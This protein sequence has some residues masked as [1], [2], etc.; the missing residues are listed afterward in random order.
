VDSTLRERARTGRYAYVH[1]R[2]PDFAAGIWVI[3]PAF[4]LDALHHAVTDTDDTQPATDPAYFAGAHLDAPDLRDAL[5][6][7]KARRHD[8]RQRHADAVRTNLGLG[9]D[10]RAGLID[11]TP[12]Q[13]D[14]LRVIVCRLL[15]RE[16]RDVLAYGAGWT[17]PDRQRPIGESGRH[18]PMPVD[19]II[20]AELQRALGETDPLR[21]IAA[22]V[23]RLA[24]AFVLDPDGITRTKTLGHERMSRKLDEALPGGED[25]LREALWSFLRP[26]LSPRLADLHRDTFITD[27][28]DRSTVDL[29]AQ[30]ADT[31]LDDLEL[32]EPSAP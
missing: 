1:D 2:G 27:P 21:G 24:A 3:D 8:Q 20:D 26:M 16:Y 4:M 18:E 11:P 7:E 22:L 30:R 5:A 19:A 32:D 29:A 17:D 9:H 10:L 6:D 13:L 23:A 15:A 14:A 12:S 28:T 31:N 25:P